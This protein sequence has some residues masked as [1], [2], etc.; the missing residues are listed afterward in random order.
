MKFLA[1]ENFPIAS[2]KLLRENGYDIKSVGVEFAGILDQEVI[3]YANAENRSI[4][5]F[6]S[7]YGELIFK[8]G[9]KPKAGVIYLRIQEFIPEEP[10]RIILNLVSDDEFDP[11]YKLTVISEEG[12]RQRKY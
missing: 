11:K 6:D 2:I 7:D 4:L 12:I 8:Y 10:G 1:N 9:L 5:T 3:D